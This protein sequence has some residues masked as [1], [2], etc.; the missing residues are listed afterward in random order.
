MPV[1][2]MCLAGLPMCYNNNLDA[3]IAMAKLRRERGA[4]LLIYDNSV[5]ATDAPAARM[6][7]FGISGEPTTIFHT[8]RWA[9][10]ALFFCV[11]DWGQGD[12]W[13][14]PMVHCCCCNATF[15]PRLVA[16]YNTLLYPGWDWSPDATNST[17][18]QLY[19]I[20][21]LSKALE[22]VEYFFIWTSLCQ[23]A[24]VNVVVV[25]VLMW[26]PHSRVLLRDEQCCTAVQYRHQVLSRVSEATWGFPRRISMTRQVR[27]Q[28]THHY[29]SMY[30]TM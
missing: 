18:E 21:L 14:Q 1:V 3:A 30:W 8:P 27:I 22:D 6:G 16:G 20:E 9:T 23:C 4:E 26:H 19:S 2:T 28:R 7:L 15:G 12:P 13:T 10:G 5:P 25:G 24:A 11:N 29:G 17:T